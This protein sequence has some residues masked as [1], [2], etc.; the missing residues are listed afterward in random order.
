MAEITP[1]NWQEAMNKCD[2]QQLRY[3]VSYLFGRSGLTD[4]E[5][6]DSINM[7]LGGY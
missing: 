5:F 3:L 4:E 1:Q 7:I 6:I 2:K